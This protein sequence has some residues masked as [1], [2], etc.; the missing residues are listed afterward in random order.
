LDIEGNQQM[1]MDNDDCEYEAE[2]NGA[3]TTD[4][5]EIHDG[6]TLGS[7]CRSRGRS[8]AVKPPLVPDSEDG[9]TVI[10]P[11]GDG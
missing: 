11:I 4:E 7:G 6:I 8:H 3:E 5:H 9:K 2:N 10:R 1:D